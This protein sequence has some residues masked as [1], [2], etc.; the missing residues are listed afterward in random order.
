MTKQEYYNLLVKTSAEG[1]FPATECWGERTEPTCC[2]R[3]KDGRKCAAGL[4]IPD[5]EYSP[6]MENRNFMAIIN[7]YPAL[8]H[9]IPEGM[10]ARNVRQIQYN[11]HDSVALYPWSHEF[12]V[13]R[14]N[15]LDCFHNVEKVNV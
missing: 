3:T 10:T 13:R 7:D 2:Y 11:I 1:R 9:C 4:L 14:L 6:N 8:L 5:D 12:F 15:Q